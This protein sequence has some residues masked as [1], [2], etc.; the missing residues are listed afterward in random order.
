MTEIKYSLTIRSCVYLSLRA[1][2]SAIG[3]LNCPPWCVVLAWRLR[4]GKAEPGANSLDQG[5]GK[6]AVFHW[7][8]PVLPRPVG[9]VALVIMERA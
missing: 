7:A 2:R 3:S 9:G 5:W 4:E 6:G 8:A 1:M